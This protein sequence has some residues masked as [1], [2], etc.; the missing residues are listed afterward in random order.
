MGSGEG[1]ALS[2]VENDAIGGG[3]GARPDVEPEA[4]HL[5]STQ[6]EEGA[7]HPEGEGLNRL[8][9]VQRGASG[10]EL[11]KA[12]KKRGR[13]RGAKNKPKLR[14]A[15]RP[16]DMVPPGEVAQAKL[17]PSEETLRQLAADPGVRYLLTVQQQSL[18]ESYKAHLAQALEAK[19]SELRAEFD[20]AL[21][22]DR[23]IRAPQSPGMTEDEVRGIVRAELSAYFASNPGPAM[24]PVPAQAGAYP[25]R[26]YIPS[27]R[28]W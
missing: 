5:G 13:P 24:P 6:V 23:S 18:G 4:V 21:E 16:E 22:M 11:P 27:N 1:E 17:P 15:D 19:E 2:K 9:E 25:V 10:D 20:S 3:A 7:V 26:Q 28:R 14:A 8:S 12:G